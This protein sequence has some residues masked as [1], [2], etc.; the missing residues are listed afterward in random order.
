MRQARFTL[1]FAALITAVF[2][3]EMATRGPGG[4]DRFRQALGFGGSRL[5]GR[6]WWRLFTWVLINPGF[7][8]TR[9]VS[10]LAH[11]LG[12]LAILLAAGL[13][14]ERR[15]G[16]LPV[17]AALVAGTVALDVWLLTGGF[18]GY[19]G[20]SS[21]AVF[22]VLGGALASG[23]IAGG[24]RRRFAIGDGDGGDVL[25]VR[26]GRSFVIFHLAAVGAGALAGWLVLR[27]RTIGQAAHEE[28][29]PLPC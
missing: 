23:V 24:T 15:V 2:V 16:S 25:F 18:Y 8:S 20:G 5:L 13:V 4:V 7:T 22:G 29:R 1:G 14:M 26:Q 11:L 27:A 6:D 21:G 12:S 28:H 19:S 17:I 3:A 9:P 10:P